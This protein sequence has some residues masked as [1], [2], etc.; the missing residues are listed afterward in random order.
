MRRAAFLAAGMNDAT[1]YKYDDLS[2]DDNDHARFDDVRSA[3]MAVGVV[4]LDGLSAWIG[5]SLV[6]RSLGDARPYRDTVGRGI[7]EL[8]KFLKKA[9]V[10]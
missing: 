8:G 9:G 3:A 2:K 4:K 7:A 10:K 1:V 6:S 5:A